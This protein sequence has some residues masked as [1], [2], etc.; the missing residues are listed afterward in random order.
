MTGAFSTNVV[1]STIVWEGDVSPGLWREY[2]GGYED[3]RTQRERAAGLAGSGPGR[4]A[5]EGAASGPCQLHQGR[6]QA[7][8]AQLQGAARA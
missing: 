7:A 5:G 3:W 1:T 8:Q 6:S 2:E 4:T